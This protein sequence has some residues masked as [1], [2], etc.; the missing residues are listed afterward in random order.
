MIIIIR[1]KIINLQCD[2]FWSALVSMGPSQQGDWAWIKKFKKCF[3]LKKYSVSTAYLSFP[4]Y[5][6]HMCLTGL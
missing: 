4:V 2:L 6:L 5:N 1:K 3:F